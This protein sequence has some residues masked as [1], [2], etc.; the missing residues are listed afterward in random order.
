MAAKQARSGNAPAALSTI[1]RGLTEL[2]R[3]QAA[4]GSLDLQTALAVHGQRMAELGL[5]IAV[6]KGSPRMVFEWVERT[7]ALS[8]RVEP[9][10]PPTDSAMASDLTELRMLSLR[11]PVPAVMSQNGRPNSCILFGSVPGATP[12][13]PD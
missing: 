3:T 5:R 8:G 6:E 12:D 9:V 1:R 7:G 11:S 4:L 13:R 10:R 2:H